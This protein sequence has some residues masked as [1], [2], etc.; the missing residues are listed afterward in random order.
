M[1][2]NQ[3]DHIAN[4]VSHLTFNSNS[5]YLTEQASYRPNIMSGQHSL[6]HNNEVNDSL[7]RRDLEIERFI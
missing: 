5:S 2:T 1:A 4:G 3:F 6:S 7:M